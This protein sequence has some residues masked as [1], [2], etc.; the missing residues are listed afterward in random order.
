M[1]KALDLNHHHADI[2]LINPEDLIWRFSGYLEFGDSRSRVCN[3]AAR[4]VQRMNRDWMTT[5]RRPA[6]ICGGALILA[7]RMNNFRRTTREMS[8]IVKVAE[9][10]ILKRL[11]EFKVTESS[12]LTV[13]EF[14]TIDLERACDPPAFYE[15]K[16]G[17]KKRIRKRK[18]V[19]LDDEEP[20]DIGSERATS[21]VPPDT[22]NQLQTPANTQSQAQS[23]AQSMPPPPVPIDPALLQISAQRS[24]EL[25][26]S[27][28]RTST[29][30][31]LATDDNTEPPAKRKR[32]RKPGKVPNPPPPSRS[33]LEHEAAIE[34]E[35]TDFVSD[36][37]NVAQASALHS[38]LDGA[39]AL[40][41]PPATQQQPT[42]TTPTEA[43]LRV[44]SKPPSQ[45]P[46]HEFPTNPKPSNRTLSDP[47][48]TTS[49]LLSTIPSTPIVPDS[50]FASDP[51]VLNCLLSPAEIAIKERI[52][53][54]ENREYLRAQS[55][56]L[57]KQQLAEQNGT[58]RQIVRRKRRRG[59][60]GD[61]SGY[62]IEGSEEGDGE[63]AEGGG[64]KGPR[65]P[66]EATTMMMKRRGYSRK[67]NYKAIDDLYVPS[68][69][70]GSRAS[71]RRPESGAG[72]PGDGSPGHANPSKTDGKDTEEG[73]GDGSVE[74]EDD[75]AGGNDANNGD[76]DNP[77]DYINDDDDDEAEGEGEGGQT[78][79]D[80]V[81][82]LR[83]EG[84]LE[85]DDDDGG[86]E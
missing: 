36:P 28:N 16:D 79:E 83:E 68:S 53:V 52:W 86:Y 6:G 75:A 19:E 73:N 63:G 40:P 30:P 4:I 10:T 12:G 31:P 56:K 18:V 17:K 49:S 61:V 5:G 42:E 9:V 77:D 38:S 11:D 13:D 80:I 35:I 65:T 81:A 44:P 24:S 20:S 14:R 62:G 69:S 58:A 50:E 48:L 23:D 1:L 22:N 71:S 54:H 2:Q 33:E 37:S 43:T 51:E 3:E 8:H 76:E 34:S 70:S 74:A 57:L 84:E 59:R 41:S 25:Q 82:E 72:S 60:M 67:I 46:S 32:G 7:A 27:P 66:A 47:K 29:S 55:A 85:D 39:P 45:D 64:A 26:P 21:V 78:L 15:Q